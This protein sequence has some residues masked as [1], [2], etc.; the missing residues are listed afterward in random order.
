MHPDRLAIY[1]DDVPA[2]VLAER[3]RLTIARLRATRPGRRSRVIFA[4]ATEGAVFDGADLR[5]ALE[6]LL[7]A[8]TPSPTCARPGV[9]RVDVQ[10]K[11]NAAVCRPRTR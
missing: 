3:E 2:A 6:K 1:L 4:R 10:K 7:G 11:L 5:R 8:P 9:P